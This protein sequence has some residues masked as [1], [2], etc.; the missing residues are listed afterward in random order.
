MWYRQPANEWVEALP[1]G[2]GRLAGMVFGGIER[3]R[4]QL[5]EDTLWA[6]GPYDPANPQALEAL[7]IARRL[8]FAGKYGEAHALVAEKMLG[9]PVR[10]MPFQPVGDLLLTFPAA[11]NVDGYRRELDLD[12]AVARVTYVSDGVRFVREVLS[13]PVDQ[14]IAVRLTADRPGRINVTAGMSTPQ[15]A[16]IA[17]EDGRTI[18]MRGVNAESQGIKGALT[19]EARVRVMAEG[20]A[21]SADKTSIAVAGRRSGHAPAGRGDQL[22]ELQ[23]RQRRSACADDVATRWGRG[24][25]VRRAAP[26]ARRGA[27]ASVSP[28]HT[29]LERL[30]SPERTYPNMFDAHPPFQID[31]NFGGTAGIAEMLLA[32]PWRRNR[33]AAGA[34]EE[35]VADR[36]G[37]RTARARWARSR[38]QLEGRHAGRP[39]PCARWSVRRSVCATAPP[40]EPSTLRRGRRISGR[41]RCAR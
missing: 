6:G 24:E 39:R 17:T 11:V 13:S 19:F 20:G 21:V 34:S 18:V 16:T 22:Q 12:T 5:N 3:E 40:R 31:G 23:G 32:E 7:P 33:T 37:Q 10:Q 29:I 26:G 38:H 28:R 1:I 41:P 4:I 25:V 35:G 27:P 2:N 9:R 14:V 15:D 36:R 8:I 30:L